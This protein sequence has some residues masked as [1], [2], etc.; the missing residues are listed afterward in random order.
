MFESDDKRCRNLITNELIS[1]TV[2]LE[3]LN[4]NPELEF[5]FKGGLRDGIQLTWF[6]NGSSIQNIIMSMELNMVT[7][8]LGMT[9]GIY[10][11]YSFLTM[12]KSMEHLKTGTKNSR[13]KW[14]R[15]YFE[16][17]EHGLWKSWYNNGQLE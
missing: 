15:E 14:H 9:M 1:G 10:I 2:Y 8:K 11:S 7:A 5:N 12:D 4:G 17:E 16:G 3:T 13:L 6:K